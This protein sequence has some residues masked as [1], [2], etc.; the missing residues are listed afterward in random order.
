M[1]P[2]NDDIVSV[3]EVGGTHVTAAR[4]DRTGQRVLAG[5]W[6]RAPLDSGG[7]ADEI[8]ASLARCAAQLPTLTASRWAVAVPGPFDYACGIGRYAGVGKFDALNGVDLRFAL[9]P[10]LPGAVSISFHNDAHA[11]GIGEWWAGAAA[12]RRSAVA[13]TL[14]TGIGSCFLRDGHVV[15]DGPAVP[16]EGRADLIRYEGRPLEET[17]SRRALRRA[18]ARATGHDA[19]VHEIAERARNGDYAAAQVFERAFGVLGTVLA[20]YLAKFAPQVVVIGG[21]IAASWDLVI[22]PLQ[23]GLCSAEPDRGAR[24][25]LVPAK[26]PTTAPVLGAAYLDALTG[27]L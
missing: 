22:A 27:S 21:S 3:L 2:G 13:V 16:P 24:I 18:Y 19:D 15:Q 6:R 23:A 10:R 7:S 25:R 14:G 8:V 20:P 11:F 9:M 17:V 12:G 1:S 26:H 4:V 5:L